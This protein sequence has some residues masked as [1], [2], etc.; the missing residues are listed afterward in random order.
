M[1]RLGELEML[2]RT[3]EL[4]PEESDEIDRIIV[5]ERKRT[6]YRNNRETVLA[7]QK[8]RYHSDPA[9]KATMNRRT[10]ESRRMARA[11]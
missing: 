6:W 8:A 2:S 11:R 1:D 4:T 7:R 9:F 10:V 5:S 3:R